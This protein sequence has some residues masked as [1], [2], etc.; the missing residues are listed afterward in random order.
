ME[1]FPATVVV[2]EDDDPASVVQFEF[3]LPADPGD[4][5]LVDSHVEA[6]FPREPKGCP[7]SRGGCR[8]D[9]RSGWGVGRTFRLGRGVA[10]SGATR[11]KRVVDVATGRQ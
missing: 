4:V 6:W 11:Q 9:G 8:A 5:R 2:D 1:D 3:V 10:A 7:G